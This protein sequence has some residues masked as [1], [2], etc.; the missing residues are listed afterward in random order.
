MVSGT[1]SGWFSEP[2]FILFDK[3]NA[4]PAT[5]KTTFFSEIVLDF[6]DCLLGY[7]DSWSSERQKGTIEPPHRPLW[8]PSPIL[9]DGGFR[10]FIL[11]QSFKIV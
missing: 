10:Q 2:F 7:D 5:L 9:K 4:H 6:S 1:S 3:M 8:T 11:T